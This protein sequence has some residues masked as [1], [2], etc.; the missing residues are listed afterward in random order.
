M[1]YI[2]YSVQFFGGIT[3]T[4]VFYRVIYKKKLC[5]P[6]WQ[7]LSLL[8]GIYVIYMAGVIHG[9][10]GLIT[11]SILMGGDFLGSILFTEVEI[12]ENLKYWLVK[13]FSTIA[14]E[15][16]LQQGLRFL[17]PVI[18]DKNTLQIIFVTFLMI[19]ILYILSKWSFFRK[20]KPLRLSGKNAMLLS[21][22]FGILILFMTFMDTVINEYTKGRVQTTAVLLLSFAMVGACVAMVLFLYVFQQKAYFQERAALENEYNEQQR[23][24]FHTLLE[25]ENET[26]KFRHDMIGH[27]LC[28]EDM[29]EKGNVGEIRKYLA[30]NL[31][32]L[33]QIS[34]KEYSIGNETIDVLLNHYFLPMRESCHVEVEGIFGRAEHISR[35]ELCTIFSNV[36]KNAV[37]AVSKIPPE[38]TVEKYIQICASHGEKYMKLM[39][40]NT[41]VGDIEVKDKKIKTKKQDV[42]NHGFGIENA[43]EAVERCGGSFSYQVE[44]NCFLVQ[45]I[46]HVK[47]FS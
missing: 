8:A 1:E 41:Y 43:H 25:K 31:H 15:S 28:L 10:K 45:I 7:C 34:K 29:A 30:E 40:R 16:V 9:W 33:N 38:S 26:R 5:M 23:I 2:L 27:M 14:L 18:N 32:V 19:I 42:Q 12:V 6:K 11:S 35:M 39:V 3:E 22:S 44:Q 24:Y 13:I 46:L 17:F 20:M 21:A 36:F 37:E 4:L 47:S